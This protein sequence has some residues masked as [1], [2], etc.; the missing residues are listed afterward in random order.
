MVRRHKT[1]IF[2]D[3]KESTTVME[4]KRMVEGILKHSPDDQRLYKGETLLDDSKTLGDSG[5]TNSTAK[6]QQPAEIGLAIKQ[7]DGEFEPLLIDE[8]SK[9]PELPEV[10]KPQDPKA[11]DD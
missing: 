4:L 1:T 10:M 11:G 2:L 7:E 9:P 8:L 6:A 3:A 5:F